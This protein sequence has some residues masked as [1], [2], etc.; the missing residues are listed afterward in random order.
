V[1]PTSHLGVPEAKAR[2]SSTRIAP[3]L[4]P[5]DLPAFPTLQSLP[6]CHTVSRERQTIIPHGVPYMTKLLRYFVSEDSIF[7]HLEH[8]QGEGGPSGPFQV[9]W[10]LSFVVPTHLKC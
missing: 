7:L 10:P 8:V 5:A 3:G 4:S 2:I 6:R 9:L 1:A